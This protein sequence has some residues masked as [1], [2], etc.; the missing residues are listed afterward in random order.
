VVK[1]FVFLWVV[2]SWDFL[3]IP[4]FQT[5]ILSPSSALQVHSSRDLCTFCYIK[6][7]SKSTVEGVRCASLTAGF[8]FDSA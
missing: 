7:L 3:Q 2:S 4:T 8:G 5:N 1:M 6:S